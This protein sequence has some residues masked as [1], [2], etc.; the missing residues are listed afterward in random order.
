[1][2][3][4]YWAQVVTSDEGRS[5]IL[6]SP[7]FLSEK[8]LQ[9]WLRQQRV[10]FPG[11]DCLPYRREIQQDEKGNPLSYQDHSLIDTRYDD[12]GIPQDS[13]G[14]DKLHGLIAGMKDTADRSLAERKGGLKFKKV[15]LKHPEES[16][17]VE[18]GTQSEGAQEATS[19]DSDL[20]TLEP[21]EVF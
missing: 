20:P 3:T 13:M 8:E 19:S 5:T 6:N 1:M 21:D 17:V 16:P 10:R 11:A 12:V 9:D 14:L 7:V 18:D 2:K 15:P 4:D